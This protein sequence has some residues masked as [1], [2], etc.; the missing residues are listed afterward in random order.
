LDK[1]LPPGQESEFKQHLTECKECSAMYSS[2]EEGF[3]NLNNVRE[4]EPKAFFTESV[5]NKIGNQKVKES[6]FDVTV[7]IAISAFFKKFA[8]TGVAFIIALFILLY[9]TD[10]LFLFNNATDDDVFTSNRISSAFFD[11]N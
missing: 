11:N 9:T 1:E 8:Y 5:F 3:I 7:E 6:I 2:I 10:N 4:I